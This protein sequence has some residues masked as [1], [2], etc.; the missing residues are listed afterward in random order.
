MRFINIDSCRLL[1]DM[2]TVDRRLHNVALSPN[3]R[4]VVGVMED[5]NLQVFSLQAL[6][7]DINK[8]W[9][10]LFVSVCLLFV[11]VLISVCFGSCRLC[12]CLSLPVV[13]SLYLSVS[14]AVCVCVSVSLCLSLSVSLSVCLCLCLCL[15]LSLSLSLSLP[16]PPISLLPSFCLSLLSFVSHSLCVVFSPYPL[17][18]HPPLCV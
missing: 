6:C 16:P 12:L 10:C 5:G 1:F 4:Y 13:L 8:V 15:C 3:G 14:Y 18:P 7:A 17:P 11:S 9:V 2:G